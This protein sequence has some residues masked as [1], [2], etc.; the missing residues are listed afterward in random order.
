MNVFIL[1][2]SSIKK[3]NFFFVID[4]S[5]VV[6]NSFYQTIKWVSSSSHQFRPDLIET[7]GLKRPLMKNSRQFFCE[8]NFISGFSSS[9][10]LR[11]YKCINISMSRLLLVKTY[12]KE[13]FI[14]LYVYGSRFSYDLLFLFKWEIKWWH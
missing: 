2:I 12:V 7:I 5:L 6:I 8:N 4:S 13:L 9:Y 14:T 1:E 3:E 10:L 11:A